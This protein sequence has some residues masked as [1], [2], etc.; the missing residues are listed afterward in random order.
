M[1]RINI[2]CSSASAE[3]PDQGAASGEGVLA[4]SKAMVRTGCDAAPDVAVGTPEGTPPK[5]AA[6]SDRRLTI[7]T[8]ERSAAF[9]YGEGGSAMF[10]SYSPVQKG[11][12]NEL[13]HERPNMQKLPY[14]HAG[15]WSGPHPSLARCLYATS[16]EWAR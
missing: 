14:W 12:L 7:G 1:L 5:P 9:I 8:T 4:S 3:W 11:M 6:M 15:R 13:E 2:K 16:A 10:G